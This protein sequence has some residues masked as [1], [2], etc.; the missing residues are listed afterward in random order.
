VLERQLHIPGASLE[1]NEEANWET[2]NAQGNKQFTS[3]LDVFFSAYPQEDLLALVEDSL[4]SDEESVV[5]QVGR[6][7]IFIS[8]KS[9]IDTIDQNN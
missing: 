7:I 8:C 2:F 4:Q 1:K 5:S 6:E 9:I 3:I